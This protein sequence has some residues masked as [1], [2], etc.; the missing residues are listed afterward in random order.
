MIYLDHNAT[1]PLDPRVL[2]AMMPFLTDRFGNAASRH[3]PLGCDA[4]T[5][6]ETA[7]AQV[8]STIGADPREIVWTSGATESDNLALQG[9]LG[10][11]VYK[12]RHVVTV[13]T[14]HRA[15]L[16]T[17]E[18][19][20]LRD[21]DVTYLPVDAA[22]RIDLD[23]LATAITR[24]TLLVS[25]MHG[26]NETGVIHPIAQIGARCRERGVL[27]HTD[28]TQTFAK[29]PID[30]NAMRIDLLSASAHKIHGPKG[31]GVLYVRRR[32]PRVR[33][34]PLLHG[35]GHERGLRSGT[36]NVPAVVGM[37]VAATLSFDERIGTL[38]DRLEQALVSRLDDVEVNGHGAARLATT[39]NLSF[40]GVDGAKLMKRMPDLAV[41]SSS[42]CTSALLQPS[43]VLGAMGCDEARARGS[44][45]FSLGR[46]T[47]EAEVDIAVDTVVEAVTALRAAQE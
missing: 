9:V 11:P 13:A 19:L 12:K 14:E 20:A 10:S 25:V 29:I 42:A 22:G 45:R 35:G 36:L 28:A 3:H 43:Y 32:D 1:T 37:G 38:R 44:V 5:A 4:A 2:D 30:V 17:C 26:N 40:G 6:V 24:E 31:V 15:V 8:A 34:Q 18:V 16:D 47:T 21:V 7:R 41:S 23:R 39:T 27:F 46:F 33:C